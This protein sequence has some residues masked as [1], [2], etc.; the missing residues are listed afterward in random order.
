MRFYNIK[1]HKRIPQTKLAKL[2]AT[3]FNQLPY[4]VLD[5]AATFMSKV[6]GIEQNSESSVD[7]NSENKENLP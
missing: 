7:G 3:H 6:E 5:I 2:V 1:F 4:D